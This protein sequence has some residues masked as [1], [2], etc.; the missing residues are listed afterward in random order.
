MAQTKSKT[1]T[2]QERAER[3]KQ[4]AYKAAV[5]KAIT[6]RRH[7]RPSPKDGPT[8]RAAQLV[9]AYFGAAM[10]VIENHLRENNLQAALWL[11]S[12]HIEIVGT[13]LAEP[14]ELPR[15]AT[16]IDA[17]DAVI[18]Q[19]MSGKITIETGNKLLQGIE[20]HATIATSEKIDELRELVNDLMGDKAR[21]I[22][23]TAQEKNPA[24]LKLMNA[25]PANDM[26]AE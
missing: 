20:R 5:S 6:A 2:D 3:R 16:P 22:D 24:W 7:K 15:D 13:R 23:G 21:T 9:E 17:A 4:G 19:M 1:L 14:I 8:V 18:R 12:K 25:K 26:P 11:A 10:Q